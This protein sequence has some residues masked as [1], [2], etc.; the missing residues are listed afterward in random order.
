MNCEGERTEFT[1]NLP[2]RDEMFN[3]DHMTE[4]FMY[5]TILLVDNDLANTN[6]VLNSFRQCGIACD[7]YTNMGDLLKAVASADL[8]K[9]QGSY[10]CLV[11][12]TLYDDASYKVLSDQVRS[13]L[14]T[15]GSKYSVKQSRAHYRSLTQVL[16]SVLMTSFMGFIETL[17]DE[18]GT[19]MTSNSLRSISSSSGVRS[20]QRQSGTFSMDDV[21]IMMAEDNKI[22]Q[23][24]LLRILN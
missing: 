17:S 3:V 12:E 13:V 6:E 4:K 23:K 20:N 1:V 5:T 11:E 16:P 2:Y 8:A 9:P 22:N 15:F 24:V 19:E 10:I 21:R 14:I 7:V 18:K